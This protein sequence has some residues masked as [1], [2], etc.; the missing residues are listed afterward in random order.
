MPG[1][2][3][4]PDIYE[5]YYRQLFRIK[6]LT[7]AGVE[8]HR[9]LTKMR[10]KAK[11]TKL[12]QKLIDGWDNLITEYIKDNLGHPVE[13][14]K[15]FGSKWLQVSDKSFVDRINQIRKK[16]LGKDAPP[17]EQ[18]YETA[19][20]LAQLEGMYELGTLLAHP[21]SSTTNALFG[22]ANTAYSSGLV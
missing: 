3:R 6:H 8:S 13:D 4:T 9:E 7:R 14:R 22:T 16:I 11:R 12:N 17:L 1:W 15:A 20:R 5:E 10:E 19:Y 18:G 2:R 21:K